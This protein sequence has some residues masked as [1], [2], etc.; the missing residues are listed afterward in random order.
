[1]FSTSCASSPAYETEE[2]GNSLGG[3]K[4]RGQAQCASDGAI[5]LGEY[6]HAS[7]GDY[8]PLCGRCE[9][10]DADAILSRKL[11]NHANWSATIQLHKRARMGQLGRCGPLNKLKVSN[12][13]VRAKPHG[14]PHGVE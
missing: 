13:E 2:D 12:V 7:L 10:D 3:R 1:M 11:I 5:S 4:A 8:R 14:L 9:P 6:G